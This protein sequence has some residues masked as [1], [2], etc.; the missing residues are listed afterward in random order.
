[1]KQKSLVSIVES[2]MHPN[3]SELYSKKGLIE[4]KVNSIRKAISQIKKTPVDYIVAEFFYA[5][6][7]N[8]SGVHK[9]NLDVL[10][11]SLAKYSPQTRVI[12]LVEKKEHQ[13]VEVLNALNFPLHGVLVHPA[14]AEQIEA[15]LT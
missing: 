9:S 15:L 2:S 11:I 4:T 13:Y 1:M 10:L 3:Y 6:S 7:T 14:R 5:Y 12:V 8:Y